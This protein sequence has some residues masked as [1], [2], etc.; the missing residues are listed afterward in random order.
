MALIHFYSNDYYRTITVYLEMDKKCC[1]LILQL[2]IKY[3]CCGL[4]RYKTNKINRMHF[5]TSLSLSYQSPEYSEVFISSDDPANRDD[6]G[7]KAPKENQDG[8]HVQCSTSSFTQS[9]E[10]V[11]AKSQQRPEPPPQ[12]SK[13]RLGNTRQHHLKENSGNAGVLINNESIGHE[14]SDK[15]GP[16]SYTGYEYL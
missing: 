11:A 4:I 3:N 8:P 14:M 15:N 1:I 12:S 10:D 16:E 13:P 5:I 9:E 6:K 2:I 7:Q